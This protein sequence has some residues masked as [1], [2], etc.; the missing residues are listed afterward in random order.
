MPHGNVMRVGNL[1][2]SSVAVIDVEISRTLPVD[3]AAEV[4]HELG[5]RLMADE[6]L[7]NRLADTPVVVGVIDVR[8]D[9]FVMRMS[10]TTTPSNRELVKRAWRRLALQAFEAGELVAPNPLAPPPSALTLGRR[11]RSPGRR[12]HA[13]ANWTPDATPPPPLTAAGS[14]VNEGGVSHKVL[15]EAAPSGGTAGLMER[16]QVAPFGLWGHSARGRV[17]SRPTTVNGTAKFPRRGSPLTPGGPGASARRSR[18]R[19][20]NAASTAADQSMSSVLPPAAWISARRRASS[21]AARFDAFGEHVLGD[22]G[23]DPSGQRRARAAGADRHRRPAAAGHGGQDERAV[24]GVVGA[25]DPHLGGRSIGRDRSVHGRIVGGGDDE[26]VRRRPRRTSYGRRCSV[27]RERVESVDELGATTVTRAPASTRPVALRRPTGPPPTTSTGDAAQ[28][29]EH[30]IPERHGANLP[31]QSDARCQ[32]DPDRVIVR[33]GDQFHKPD[34]LCRD[35]VLGMSLITFPDSLET[36]Q[37]ADTLRWAAQ[38]FG[39][40]NLVVTASFEDAVL[41]HV[42]ATAVPGIEIVLLDTQYLFAET[43]WLVDELT[44]RLDLNLRVVHPLPDVQPDNLWQTDIEGVLRVRK[45]EPLNRSLAGQAGVGHRRA[46][47]RRPHPRQ[48]AGRQLRHRPQHRQ[49]QPARHVHRRRHG[50]LRAAP[51][52]A[53]QPAH[54][55]RLSVDRLLAVHPSGRAGRGQARRPLGRQ[56]QDRMRVARMS[57]VPGANTADVPS[58]A[59]AAAAASLHLDALDR[60]GDHDHPRGRRRVPEPGAAVQRRQG[61]RG[62]A[63]PRAARRSPRP[64]CRSR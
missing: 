5:V 23:S 21:T 55:A 24:V 63:A 14:E 17:K 39:V 59:S 47:G 46:P 22:L 33:K 64:G 6:T 28:V 34:R 61:L 53:G 49:A 31:G 54:R 26:L 51:R 48:R 2:K 40:E 9:R 44:K 29:E 12:R 20:V 4:L 25:V 16:L 58:S 38:Q 32:G 10:V 57:A 3:A 27:R 41:V 50:A 13:A 62:A 30:R 52:A 1:S 36:G 18:R 8:D 43:K 19:P 35:R 42:A 56:R 37:P 60:R 45:V 7:A 11:R 15:Q